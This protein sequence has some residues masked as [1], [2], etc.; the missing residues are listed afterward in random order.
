M[1]ACMHA[2]THTY[3]SV[4]RLHLLYG[5]LL[6]RL[7]DS[8][9]EIRVA[10]TKTLAAYIRYVCTV[11][12]CVCMSAYNVCVCACVCVGVCVYVCVCVCVC[13]CVCVRL[14]MYDCVISVL[15]CC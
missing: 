9:D 2:F 7:D 4:D 10:V 15:V 12:V 1:H 6:K 14:Y 13:A 11:C 5:E 8:S 3:T